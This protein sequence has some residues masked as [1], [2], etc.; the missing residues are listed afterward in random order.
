MYPCPMTRKPTKPALGGQPSHWVVLPLAVEPSPLDMKPS[1]GQARVKVEKS[2]V[3]SDSFA[4][5]LLKIARKA[6]REAAE[7]HI[8]AGRLVKRTGSGS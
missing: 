1:P 2:A 7:A 8:K 6:T 5:A 3:G 4:E